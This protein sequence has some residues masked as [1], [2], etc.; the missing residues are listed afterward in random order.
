MTCQQCG[1][2]FEGKFCPNCGAP[3]AADAQGGQGTAQPP[4]GNTAAAQQ[5]NG[6]NFSGQS[7]YVMPPNA[8]MPPQKPKKKFYK[9]WWF[10]LL[11]VVV[12]LL[13]LGSLGGGEDTTT[14]TEPTP[15]VSESVTQALSDDTQANSNLITVP[16]FSTMS[17]EDMEAWAEA[18]TVSLRFSDEYSD[19]IPE[20]GLISQSRNVNDQIRAGGTIQ[21]VLSKGPKPPMEYLNALAKAQTYSDMMHMSKQGIYDQLVSEYGEAFPADAAQYAIDHLEADYFANALEKAKTYAEMMNMS[22]S[23]IYDQLVSEYGEQFTPEEAQYAID[24]L[25]D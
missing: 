18:N 22:K 15:Q 13:I 11:I 8:S 12:V 21:I 19:A 23:A 2:V 17:K 7:T 10:W 1:S 6:A 25:E 5:P 14:P 4:A 24:H 20:G 3:A 9:R 16:D